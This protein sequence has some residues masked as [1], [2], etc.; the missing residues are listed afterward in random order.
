MDETWLGYFK[1]SNF[2]NLNMKTFL[3]FK[4]AFSL[5]LNNEEGI[6]LAY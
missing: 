5:P 3:I 1:A 6:Y 2:S 4:D